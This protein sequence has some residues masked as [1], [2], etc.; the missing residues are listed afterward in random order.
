MKINAK[1]PMYAVNSLDAA[2]RAEALEN[3]TIMVMRFHMA[4][5]PDLIIASSRD[6]GSHLEWSFLGENAEWEEFKPGTKLEVTFESWR[7]EDYLKLPQWEEL[8]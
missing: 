2:E 3:E 4:D 5:T 1:D 8:V 6:I 7:L